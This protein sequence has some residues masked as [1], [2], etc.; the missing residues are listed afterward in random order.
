MRMLVNEHNVPRSTRPVSW[1]LP[2]VKYA[3][4][5]I[6]CPTITI[7]VTVGGLEDNRQYP[8]IMNILKHQHPSNDVSF[9]FLNEIGLLSRSV[10]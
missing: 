3:Y 2:F 7:L 6:P 9:T 10:K 1:L 5:V 4:P 8:S